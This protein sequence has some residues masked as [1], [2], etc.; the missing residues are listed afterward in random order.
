ME[1]IGRVGISRSKNE[2]RAH[3]T[4]RVCEWSERSRSGAFD[5]RKL[6]VHFRKRLYGIPPHDHPFN[7]SGAPLDGGNLRREEKDSENC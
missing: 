6:D 5:T 7:G 3:V 1:Q 4:R 2:A